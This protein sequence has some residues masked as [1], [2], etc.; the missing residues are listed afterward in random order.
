M[1]TY[2]N[3]ALATVTMAVVAIAPM[4]S[5]NPVQ[6]PLN[7]PVVVSGSTGGSE[8]NDACRGFMFSNTPSQVV[9]VTEPV[10]SL[11]FRV[12]GTGQLALLITGMNNPICVPATSDGGVIEVPGVWQQGRYAVYVGDRTGGGHSYQLSIIPGN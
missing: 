1:K 12:E 8:A 6:T 5:A 11:R 4:A 9:Q 2:F 7:A 3:W 10:A